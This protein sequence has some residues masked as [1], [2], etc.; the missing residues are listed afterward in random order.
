MRKR[1]LML[2]VALTLSFAALFTSRSA[3][4]AYPPSCDCYYCSAVSPDSPCDF[5]GVWGVYTCGDFLNYYACF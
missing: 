4:A 5:A 2:M 1:L 3:W